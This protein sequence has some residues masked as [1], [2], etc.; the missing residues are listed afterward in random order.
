M[1]STKQLIDSE[2]K[3]L[4]GIVLTMHDHEAKERD[5]GLARAASAARC[6]ENEIHELNGVVNL[7][8]ALNLQV[9]EYLRPAAKLLKGTESLCDGTLVFTIS[10]TDADAALE[11]I[12]KIKYDLV[13]QAARGTLVYLCDA[14]DKVAGPERIKVQSVSNT[15][16]NYKPYLT[17]LQ[18]SK[19]KPDI[20][21]ALVS[22]GFE[23]FL[24]SGVGATVS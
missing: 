12:G 16:N 9:A 2:L 5:N 18:L 11:E 3:Q 8:A 21:T 15:I 20:T 19:F 4:V 10:P 17:N 14:M 1:T 13:F 23:H 22:A 6:L 7:T 24:E